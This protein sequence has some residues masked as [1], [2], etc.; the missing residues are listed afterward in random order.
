MTVSPEVL[1]LPTYDDI[2]GIPSETTPWRDAYDFEH[3]LDIPGVPWPLRYN[4]RG[5]ALVPT[6]VTKTASTASMAALLACERLEFS[7]TL[8]LTAGVAGAPPEL[9]VGSVVVTD[10]IV[11]WDDKCR[12]EPDHGDVPLL[13]NP[14]TEGDGYYELDTA[15]VERA[16]SL[17]AETDLTAYRPEGESEGDAPENGPASPRVLAGTN[18][19]ADE[20]WHGE[21][22]AEHVEWLVEQYDAGPYRVTEVEDAGTATALDRFDRLDQYL[23]IRAVSNHDRPTDGST[24]RENVFA[25]GFEAGFDV[26]VENMMAV[27]RPVV[28]DFL[29]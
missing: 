25:D 10:T 23:S 19:C 9:P 17:A 5:L 7:E 16:R 26:G 14:Y 11:D 21:G 28:E 20:F 6:G 13:I 24:P 27:A 12:I 18:V 15:L 22:V 1:V 2:E 29:D 3:E 4:D 8:F